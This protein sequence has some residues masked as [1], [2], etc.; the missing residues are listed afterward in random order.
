M[1]KITRDMI[2]KWRYRDGYTPEEIAH[3]LGPHD[4][5]LDDI[6]NVITHATRRQL[7]AAVKSPDFIE[8][9]LPGKDSQYE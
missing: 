1:N 3:A 5:S 8:P 7:V 9:A 2:L 6:Q 4:I